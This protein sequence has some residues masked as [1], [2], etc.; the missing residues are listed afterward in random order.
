MKT[1]VLRIS[2][3]LKT[4]QEGLKSEANEQPHSGH[5]FRVGAA[6]DLLSKASRWRR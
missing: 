4:M 1:I 2:T 6:L 3:I 5:S